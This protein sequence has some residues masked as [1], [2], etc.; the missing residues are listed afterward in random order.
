MNE[1]ERERFAEA[2]QGNPPWDYPRPQPPYVDHADRI[3]GS[4]IDIGCGTGANSLFFAE[5]G[6][7]VLGIDFV[8][9]PL[10][11]ARQRAR[12]RGLG[13]E[14]RQMDAT[15]LQTLKRRFDSVIDCG[16]FHV[17]SDRDR[18]LYTEGLAHITQT[19]SRIFLMCFSNEQPGEAG[20]R[21]ISRTEIRE[22]FAQGWDVESIVATRFRVNPE[23]DTDRFGPEGPK[24]WLAVIRRR[25]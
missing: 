5:R 21:R 19:G 6:Q 25:E 14:F 20:P 17:L 23:A 4:V 8:E 10:E 2:Y 3:I 9:K 13:V 22:A 15:Q 18:K 7:E 11:I 16:L 1:P 24:A 12:E